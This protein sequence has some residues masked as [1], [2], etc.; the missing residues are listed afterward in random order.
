MTI[1]GLTLLE[2]ND[3]SEFD[4]DEELLVGRPGESSHFVSYLADRVR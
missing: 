2:D 1:S 3:R 4:D